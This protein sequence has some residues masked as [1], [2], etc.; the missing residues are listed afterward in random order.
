MRRRNEEQIRKIREF[1]KHIKEAPKFIYNSN[2][3]KN[4]KLAMSE[5]EI[6]ADEQLVESCA[7]FLKDSCLDKLLKSLE[8]IEGAPTDSESL[9]ITFH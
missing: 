3:F 5:E 2:V 7:K 9:E 1:E 4:V 8:L 6:K